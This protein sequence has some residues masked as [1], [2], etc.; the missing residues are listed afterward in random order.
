[1]SSS[2]LR[3]KH[4]PAFRKDDIKWKQ[5]ATLPRLLDVLTS[6]ADVHAVALTWDD[7]MLQ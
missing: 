2:C 4:T 7:A 5:R 1:M 3:E 6:G